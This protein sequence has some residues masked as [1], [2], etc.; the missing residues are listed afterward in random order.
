N[1]RRTQ[2]AFASWEASEIAFAS[3]DRRVHST[4]MRLSISALVI[5]LVTSAA[6]SATADYAAKGSVATTTTNLPMSFAGANGGKLVVPNAAG[7]YPLIVASHGF[8]ANADN[9]VGWAEH[10]A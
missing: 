1:P 3:A 4:S 9:Q 7:T 10:W 5:A 6:A 8:S 2:R